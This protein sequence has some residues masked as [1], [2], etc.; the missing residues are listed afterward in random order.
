MNSDEK[1]PC[2]KHYKANYLLQRIGAVKE[3]AGAMD[4]IN[5]PDAMNE[6][7]LKTL[8]K[9]LIEIHRFAKNNL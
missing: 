6:K 8:Q 9:E 1:F 3:T 7:L 5:N 4:L 2:L